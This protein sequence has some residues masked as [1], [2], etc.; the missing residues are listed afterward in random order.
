MSYRIG[1]FCAYVRT[2]VRLSVRPTRCND[3]YSLPHSAITK[4]SNDQ[5][6]GEANDDFEEPESTVPAVFGLGAFAPATTAATST[7]FYAVERLGRHRH[8]GHR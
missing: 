4:E 5:Q 7:N 1:G 3:H 2:S 8:R 6:S